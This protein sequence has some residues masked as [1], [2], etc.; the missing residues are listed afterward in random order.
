MS[1]TFGIASVVVILALLLA[2]CAAAPTA[3]PAAST[4]A[5]AQA[6][7]APAQLAEPT[8]APAEPTAAPAATQAAATEPVKLVV[9][10]WG[11]QEAPGAQKWLDE[12]LAKYTELHPNVTFESV[13][14]STDALIPAFQSAAAAKQG[15]D[16]Q[17]FWGGVWTLENAWNGALA[18]VDDLF[19][20]EEMG[21]W[22]NNFERTYDG[23]LWGVPWYLSGNPFVYNPDLF[24]KAGVD[25]NAVK[26]WD[27]L[28][29]ACGKL[30][31]SGVVPISGGLKDGWFGG[32]LFSIL[33]RQTADSEKDFMTAV[34]TPGS[35]TEPKFA[36][37][38][39]R[40]KEL[41]D[42]GCWNEDI[43]S[44]D[45]Q[46]GQDLFVQGKSAMIFGNDTFLAGWAKDLGWD[47]M[48]VMMVPKYGSGKLAD[49]YV[50]TAQ[51]WGI[52]S[53]SKHQKEAADVL[54][55]MHTPDRLNAW[56][57]ATGVLPADNRLD[58][59]VIDQPV[60]KQIYDWDTKLG[61]P[62]LENFI[63]SMMDEQANF[64]GTQLLFA[65]E[66]TP[67]DL[68]KLTEDVLTKWREQNPDAVKN[69]ETWQK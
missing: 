19:S 62:N 37:W 14:Q 30:K 34:T 54:A 41:K 13:L 42:A 49:T 53:W 47:K 20:A 63:P 31:A 43:N 57:K 50:A 39:S 40:V 3:A 23:K 52:T 11:E 7:T 12:T 58:T 25:P 15:P 2:A 27:D 29:A 60:L 18:P 24:A 22:I 55:F 59:S 4:A 26:T 1:R 66:K 67:E 17:Y 65:G 5:P 9:W 8:A 36:E 16:I 51:G 64:A 10:W 35:F 48:G 61:G 38:W 69:F 44:V 68:A 45:Y 21:H 33:A 28:K 6:T 46:Q 32:W 56:F